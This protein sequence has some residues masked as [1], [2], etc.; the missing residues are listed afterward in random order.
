[1][2]VADQVVDGR[3]ES[4]VQAGMPVLH[5]GR[6]R[7]LRLGVSAAVNMAATR[8][9]ARVR[10]FGAGDGNV[11]LPRVFES[12]VHGDVVA[13]PRERVDDEHVVGCPR[14]QKTSAVVAEGDGR[15]RAK[16]GRL[17]LKNVDAAGRE[18]G[19]FVAHK[20]ALGTPCV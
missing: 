10:R 14:G 20:W 9:R 5:S 7:R 11:D 18:R 12:P 17:K 16:V 6:F 4:F 3:G 2:S 8:G 13:R 15:H 1:M 19:P